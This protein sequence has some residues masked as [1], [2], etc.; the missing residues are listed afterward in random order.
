MSYF[1]GQLLGGIVAI[2]VLSF[3]FLLILQRFLNGSI[4]VLASTGCAFLV[5]VSLYA[6]GSA[7]GGPPKFGAG[8]SQYGLGAVVVLFV[9]LFLNSRKKKNNG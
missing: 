2:G 9:L 8:I 3:I 6:Y 5:A 7:D 4:V 1:I